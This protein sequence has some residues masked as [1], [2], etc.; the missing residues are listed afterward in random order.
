VINKSREEIKSSSMRTL[1]SITMTF[2]NLFFLSYIFMCFFFFFLVKANA[3]SRISTRE[4]TCIDTQKEC[5]FPKTEQEGKTGPV[6]ELGPVGGGGYKE[7][8]KKGEYGGNIVYS[9]M[10]MEK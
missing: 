8:G 5:R 2:N 4:T 3:L 10:K 9:S 7:R 6:W 1:F